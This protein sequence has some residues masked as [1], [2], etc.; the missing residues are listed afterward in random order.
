MKAGL[1][2]SDSTIGLLFLFHDRVISEVQ[3]LSIVP[4]RIDWIKGMD[5][6]M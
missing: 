1:Y 5:Q 2:S 6:N 4:I 3:L